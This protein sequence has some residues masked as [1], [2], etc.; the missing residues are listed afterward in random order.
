[1]EELL[2]YT[3]ALMDVN[4]QLRFLKLIL[5]LSRKR[6]E[7]IIKDHKITKYTSNWV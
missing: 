5:V 2:K 1:M 4:I 6:R 3:R 7:G